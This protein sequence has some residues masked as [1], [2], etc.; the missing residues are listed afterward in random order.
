MTAALLHD[1]GHGAYSHTFENLFDTDHEAITQ[2]II[3]SPETEIHQVLL[4]VAPDF[5]EKVASVI[6]HTYPNK[7]VVQLI[8]SQIDADRMDYL[9]R[10][11]YFTGASYGEFD[12]TRILRVIRPCRKWDRLSAQWNACHRRLC[13]QSL[14]DVYAGLFPPC[15]TCH[16][17]SPAE[18]PQ[19][20]QGALPRGQ[21]LLCTHFSTSPPFFREESHSR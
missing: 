3:Q 8:S 5:P 20:C 14:P 6:D 12:L 21:G 10:D 7:Q 9:L 4:Q 18:S 15:N 13:S 19:T 17:S 11:S 16:G 1:L 2:E